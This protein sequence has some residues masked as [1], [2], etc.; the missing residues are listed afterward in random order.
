M[1]SRK[2]PTDVQTIV[3]ITPKAATYWYDQKDLMDIEEFVLLAKDCG[4][5]EILTR[6]LECSPCFDMMTSW[7]SFPAN[8]ADSASAQLFHFDLDRIK[9]LKVFIY[10]TDVTE[11][12]GPHVFVLGSHKRT[13]DVAYHDGRY[14]DEEVK[15]LL[16]DCPHVSLCGP[17]GTV[18]VED[19]LG[20]HKGKPVED[21]MRC[22]FEYQYSVC[23]FGYPYSDVTLK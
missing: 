6:Y 22:V 12:N 19:T 18:F 23:E 20:F 7:C 10:L 21:G 3:D 14:S 11:S 9:F 15:S 13:A 2:D 16:P 1:V 5:L 4:L 8:G 17:A